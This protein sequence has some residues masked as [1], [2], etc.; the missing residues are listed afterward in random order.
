MAPLT[1][2]S[3]YS[4]VLLSVSSTFF[5]NIYHSFITAKWRK[6]SGQNYPICYASNEVAE[7]DPNARVFNCAQRAHGNFTEN[8]TPTIAGMLIAGLR[9]PLI[10]ASLGAFWSVSRVVYVRGYVSTAGP[11]GRFTGVAMATAASFLL[12]ILAVASSVMLIRNK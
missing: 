12:Y 3:E 9:F 1:I 6:L 7:K 4:Y 11:S 2:P 8:L 10:A 5:I